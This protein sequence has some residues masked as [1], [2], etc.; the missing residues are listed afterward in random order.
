[1]SIGN[2]IISFVGIVTGFAIITFL[3]RNKLENDSMI[4]AMYA[5]FLLWGTLSRSG[6]R[7]DFFTGVAFAFFTT[8]L[9]Q[10][11]A[12]AFSMSLKEKIQ[13]IVK[14]SIAILI[15]TAFM[16]LP[17]FGAYTKRT[18][19]A[20]TQMRKVVPENNLMTAYKWI[21]KELPKTAVIAAK[22]DY[23]TQLNVF[24][25]V[26]TFTD[27]DHYIPYWIELYEEYVYHATSQRVFLEFLKTHNT[28]HLMLTHNEITTNPI[29]QQNNTDTLVPVYPTENFTHAPIKV[30]EIR[31]PD[32]IQ[33]N[34]K[35]LATDPKD[36]P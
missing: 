19:Y 26:K 21:K 27:P 30:W 36:T 5:W 18:L 11:V 17:V 29:L 7:Y 35:Y 34:P 25:N 6:I 1:M 3:Q 16:F 14:T 2:G 31:Y 24:S 12:N 4:L 15:L 32:D 23:G 20:A 22:W 13:P 10:F 33:P 28:T 9:I 8:K